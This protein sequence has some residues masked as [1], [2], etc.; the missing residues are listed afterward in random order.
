MIRLLLAL[1][2]AVTLVTVLAV[3]FGDDTQDG[4]RCALWMP[5]VVG[6]VTVPTCTRWEDE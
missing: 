6:K 1:A 3:A 2:A 5:V 4:R